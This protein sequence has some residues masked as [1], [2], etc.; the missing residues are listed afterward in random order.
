MG[1]AQSSAGNR[2]Q[3]LCRSYQE[4]CELLVRGTYGVFF[5]DKKDIYKVS[6]S[7]FENTARRNTKAK[8]VG[9][10]CIQFLADHVRSPDRG[11]QNV[12]NT[13]IGNSRLVSCFGS[14]SWQSVDA[15]Q[16]VCK[17]GAQRWYQI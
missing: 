1:R 15:R 13:G 16:I 14:K 11:I 6:V 8:N 17:T 12:F 7:S 10:S 9:V 4:R 2:T 5:V 3:Y